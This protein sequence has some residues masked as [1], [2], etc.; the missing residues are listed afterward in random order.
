MIADD[1]T[2]SVLWDQGRVLRA[3]H[4]NHGQPRFDYIALRKG[5]QQKLSLYLRSWSKV[6]LES[7]RFIL[8][9][10]FERVKPRYA[11]EGRVG[12]T[13]SDIVSE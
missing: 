12:G 13:N 10:A 8:R 3:Y 5:S 7:D 11:R 2:A 4:A 6:C 1:Y 9:C